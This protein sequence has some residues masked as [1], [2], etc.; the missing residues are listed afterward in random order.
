MGI[1]RGE[2]KAKLALCKGRGTQHSAGKSPFSLDS[3]LSWMSP[4]FFPEF[5]CEWLSTEV[6]VALVDAHVVNVEQLGKGRRRI[7]IAGP[8]SAHRGVQ[9][10]V[11]GLVRNAVPSA[12]Y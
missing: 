2:R 1:S 12:V 7:G 3:Y 8:I 4:N 10:N 5:L 11:V 9:N 6:M